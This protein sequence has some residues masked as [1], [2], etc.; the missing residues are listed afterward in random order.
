M[1]LN[2]SETTQNEIECIPFDAEIYANLPNCLSD[3][4]CVAQSPQEKDI[5]LIGALTVISACLPNIYGVYDGKI[6]YPHLYSFIDA[7]AGSGKGVLNHLRTL[8]S[9][10]HNEKVNHSREEIKRFE[11][12]RLKTSKSS[13]TEAEYLRPPKQEY[14]FIPPNISSSSFV[15]ALSDNKHGGILFTTEADTLS[16]ALSQDWGNFSDILR[17][18]FHHEPVEMQRRTNRLYMSVEQPKLSVLLSGTKDQLNRLIP[19]TENGLFSR[20]MFY[21]FSGTRE[22][23]NVF[24]QNSINTLSTMCNLGDSLYHLYQRLQ[25]HGKPVELLMPQLQQED[26]TRQFSTQLQQ[27]YETYGDQIQATIY[28]LGLIAFRISMVLSCLRWFIDQKDS[29]HKGVLD[30]LDTKTAQ[31]MTK[32]LLNNS[33]NHIE[34]MSSNGTSNNMSSKIISFKNLLPDS[35]SRGHAESIASKLGISNSTCARYLKSHH[36]EKLTHGKYAKV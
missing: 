33:I 6:V 19:S 17:C 5:L 16:N 27:N 21:S 8:G 22:F 36:F 4:L 15:D 24:S 20:F 31:N 14:L 18:A 1:N 11:Y 29:I 25:A 23:R 3:I 35:F 34:D 28:R 26:F 32:L 2:H 13:I 9:R 12:K 30:N 10:I 7:P